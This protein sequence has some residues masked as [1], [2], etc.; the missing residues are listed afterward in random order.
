MTEKKEKYKLSIY[1]ISIIGF[2]IRQIFKQNT[3]NN[4]NAWKNSTIIE[5]E[6]CKTK[7]VKNDNHIGNIVFFENL[8]DQGRGK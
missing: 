2:S 8:F 7:L 5:K 4:M 6:F 3:L 1:R